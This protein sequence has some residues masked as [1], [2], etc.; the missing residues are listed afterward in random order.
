[1]YVCVCMYLCTVCMTYI[2]YIHTYIQYIN[3]CMYDIPKTAPNRDSILRDGHGDHGGDIAEHVIQMI[4]RQGSEHVALGL[5][6]RTFV[7]QIA[8]YV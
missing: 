3:T 5:P 1:M 2:Q 7:G 8:V 6:I 4:F